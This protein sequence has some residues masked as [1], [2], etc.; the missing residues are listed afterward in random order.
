MGGMATSRYSLGSFISV[1]PSTDDVF[2]RILL[3]PMSDSAFV[4]NPIN[5][6]LSVCQLCASH[7]RDHCA[8]A[9]NIIPHWIEHDTLSAR[10]RRR[11]RRRY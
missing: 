2:S 9:A 7:G 6:D 4:M 11:R 10:R 8:H 5:I 3:T 1:L